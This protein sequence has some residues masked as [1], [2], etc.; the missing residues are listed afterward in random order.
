MKAV[1]LMNEIEVGEVVIDEELLVG[2]M[3]LDVIKE[4]PELEN[5]EVTPSAEEQHFKSEK[6]GY[7]EVKVKGVESEEITI[8]PSA[9]EQVFEGFFNKVVVEGDEDFKPENIRK[10]IEMFGLKGTMDA[11]WDSSQMRS[12][13]YMFDGNAEM[14]EPPEID[15]SNVRNMDYMHQNNTSLIR[16]GNYNTSNVTRMDFMHRGNKSLICGGNY[17]TS[18]VGR[19]QNWYYECSN[20]LS[21]PAYIASK[22]IHIPSALS[23]CSSLTDFGGFIELGKA[24][25]RNTNNYTYYKLDVRDCKNLTHESLMNVINNLYD[26]NLTYDVANGGTLYTQSLQLGSTNISKLTAEEIAIATSKGWTVS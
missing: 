15:T 17:D 7:G 11:A 3:E 12:C 21:A 1:M 16:C 6:Y 25:T 14:T 18:K 13:Q 4:Y 9:E 10:D 8:V 24:Y 20:M 26:L 22:L 2:E 23:G 5:L 19:I